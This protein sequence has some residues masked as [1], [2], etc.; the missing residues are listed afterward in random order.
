M[1][2]AGFTNNSSGANLN[3][4]VPDAIGETPLDA[5]HPYTIQGNRE[6]FTYD[7][8]N[9]EYYLVVQT[10]ECA[11]LFDINLYHPLSRSF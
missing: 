8:V 4:V 9:N 11:D 6:T 2:E 1:T 7:F 10:G 5:N 3:V